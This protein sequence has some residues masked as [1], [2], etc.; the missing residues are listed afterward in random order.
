MINVDFLLSVGSLQKLKEI[1]LELRGVIRYVFSRVFPDKEH[2]TEM[3][4][5]WRKLGEGGN[6]CGIEVFKLSN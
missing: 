1:T 4:I 5:A 6:K 3:R 2:L